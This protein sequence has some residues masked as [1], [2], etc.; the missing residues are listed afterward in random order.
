M[1]EI[2]VARRA[3][4]R[5]HGAAQRLVEG[6]RTR[7]R[8]S[9]TS[10]RRAARAS[11]GFAD[12][13]KR[14]GATSMQAREPHRLHRAR[15]GAD[16]AGMAGLAEHDADVRE[17]IECRQAIIDRIELRLFDLYSAPSPMHPMLNTA[18]KAAR[19]AGN[20]ITRATRNLDIVAV[21]R[22]ERRTISC[23]K[24]TAK[25]SDAIIRRCARPIRGTR[26]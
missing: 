18:V 11:F 24:S 13:G 25:P 2:A 23:P 6:R 14:C 19:R 17:R 20:I 7:T 21:K 22:E 16:V 1:R 8:A 10:D 15:R 9:S 5:E 4:H 3:R 12:A 26:F